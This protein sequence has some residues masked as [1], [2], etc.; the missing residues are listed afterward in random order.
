LS[1]CFIAIIIRYTE[2]ELII[3]ESETRP[4]RESRDLRFSRHYEMELI[5][6]V[7]EKSMSRNSNIEKINWKVFFNDNIH[8]IADADNQISQSSSSMGGEGEQIL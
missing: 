8:N 3:F 4:L 6:N 7:G 1:D 2:E 5:Y